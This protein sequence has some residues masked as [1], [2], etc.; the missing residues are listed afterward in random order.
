MNEFEN[1]AYFWQK[2][3]TLLSS[4]DLKIT[5]KRNTPHPKYPNLFYPVDFGVVKTLDSED[6]DIEVYKGENGKTV[7]AIVVCADILTKRFEVKVLIGLNHE[8]EENVLRFLNNTEFQ[9]TVILRKGSNIP[10]WAVS[11]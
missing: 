5:N 3:E 2:V 9:K 11:E 1:N 10:S 8:E 7:T 6:T 4:G